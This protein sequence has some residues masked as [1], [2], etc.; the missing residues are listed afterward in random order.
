MKTALIFSFSIFM[1]SAVHAVGLIENACLSSE[2]SV[3]R[4]TCSCIQQVA[5]NKLNRSDQKIAA[6]FFKNPNLAQETRQSGN[7]SKEKFWLRYK[8]WG[9]TAA[10]TCSS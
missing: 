1:A 9:Q 7:R 5:N 6:K 10:Q 8:D 3:S 2:R 4:S